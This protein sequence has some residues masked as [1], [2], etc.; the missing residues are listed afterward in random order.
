MGATGIEVEDG[1]EGRRG[2]D[3]W[4]TELDM[5]TSSRDGRLGMDTVPSMPIGREGLALSGEFPP[6]DDEESPIRAEPAWRDAVSESV[7]ARRSI[8]RLA[9]V[10]GAEPEMTLLLGESIRSWLEPTGPSM[11]SNSRE[12]SLTL[13]V[14]KG[15]DG[16]NESVVVALWSGIRLSNLSS[17]LDLK[18]ACG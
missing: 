18:E 8:L 11:L 5:V 17:G 10:L 13:G 9:G 16:P 14:A 3:V 4:D 2:G 1:M 6:R 15:V 7:A 12:R